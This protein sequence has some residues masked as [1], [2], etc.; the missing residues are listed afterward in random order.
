VTAG[1]GGGEAH[2]PN[3]TGMINNLFMVSPQK[4]STGVMPFVANLTEPAYRER[5]VIVIVVGH[6]GGVTT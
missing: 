5:L 4:G 3:T 1:G 6:R 2:P